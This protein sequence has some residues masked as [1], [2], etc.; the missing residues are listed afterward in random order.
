MPFHHNRNIM[1]KQSSNRKVTPL[2]L[3]FSMIC[4]WLPLASFNH[5]LVG[6]WSILNLDGT[7]SGEYVS[8]NED[9]T[10]SVALPD[11]RIGEKGNYLLKDSIFSIKNNKDVCGKGYWGKYTLVFYGDDS[12]H[13]TVIQDTCTERRMDMV[14]YNPGLRRY[15]QK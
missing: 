14:G 10:Y 9:N 12:V 13:F 7:A 6:K 15:K 8:F 5:T 11:G 4:L 3:V 1:R 2:F